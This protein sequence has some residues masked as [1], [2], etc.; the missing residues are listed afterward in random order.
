MFTRVALKSEKDELFQSLCQQGAALS[1]FGPQDQ[2][3]VVKSVRMESASLLA[4]W[5]SGDT[6]PEGRLTLT[7]SLSGFQ[8]FMKSTVK[9]KGDSYLFDLSEDLYKLQRRKN[10]RMKVPEGVS[11]ELEILRIGGQGMQ[12]TFPVDNVSASGLALR[13]SDMSYL[14]LSPDQTFLCLLKIYGRDFLELQGVLKYKTARAA[15]IQ[16]L[17]LNAKHEQMLFSLVM[18]LHRRQFST[19]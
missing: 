13:L 16:F 7:F 12:Q 9:K 1:V 6:L 2:K 19:H 14:P 11:V 5:Q 15:G 10:F 4:R 17:E 18:D 3:T 8:F